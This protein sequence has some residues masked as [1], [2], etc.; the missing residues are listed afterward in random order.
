MLLPHPDWLSQEKWTAILRR[1]N[2]ACLCCGG[3]LGPE[4]PP[5]V[6]HLQPRDKGGGDDLPNLALLC[7]PCHDRLE[8]SQEAMLFATNSPPT[9]NQLIGI[10]EDD[11][12][13]SPERREAM[14]T[15]TKLLNA[16]RALREYDHEHLRVMS[17]LAKRNG[18]WPHVDWSFVLQNLTEGHVPVRETKKVPR[19]GIGDL[20]LARGATD[21]ERCGGVVL[22]GRASP[23]CTA[24]KQDDPKKRID[25]ADWL[26]SQG[27]EVFAAA[28][29]PKTGPKCQCCGRQIPNADDSAVLCPL[30][31]LLRSGLTG[32]N[33]KPHSPKPTRKCPD[34]GKGML[35]R[36]RY[37]AQCARKHRRVSARD[38]YRKLRRKKLASLVGSVN[39]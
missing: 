22:P 27:Y 21:C 8:S 23:I 31:L 32:L 25:P 14:C 10:F 16:S 35:A 29:Q 19:L 36:K 28:P 1:D 24:C 33:A 7:L 18:Y 3:K 26:R 4:R 9:R 6:H 30:C 34:C 15:H 11:A 39:S 38:S 13:T 37:C 2:M 20:L 17:G 5:S 12:D